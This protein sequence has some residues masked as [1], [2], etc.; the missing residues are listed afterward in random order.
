MRKVLSFSFYDLPTRL[1]ACLFHLS[2]FP[3]NCFFE[4][5]FLIWMWVAEGF[6]RNEVEWMSLF[7]IGESGFNELVNRST[8]EIAEECL[9][10]GCVMCIR[11]SCSSCAA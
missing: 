8:I 9:N 4:K 2:I 10:N 1:R 7:E 11:L 6:V 5:D 3:E